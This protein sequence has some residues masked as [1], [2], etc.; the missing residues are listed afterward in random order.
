MT[1]K[2]YAGSCHCGEVRFEAD[3]NLAAGTGRCNCSICTKT[4]YWGTLIKPDAFRLL[5]GEP[6]LSDYQFNSGSMHHLF[7]RHCGVRPFGRGHLDILGGDFVSVNLACLDNATDAELAAAPVGYADGRNDN[8]Q[9]PP[10]E[11]RHL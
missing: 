6:A 10:A 1:T 8:W 9:Q 2:T 4:R 5:A 7:C 11:T 3:I